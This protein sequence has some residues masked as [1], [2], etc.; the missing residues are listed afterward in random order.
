MRHFAHS[1]SLQ[2]TS[3]AYHYYKTLKITQKISLKE[4]CQSFQNRWH[5]EKKNELDSAGN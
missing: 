3:Q 1:H 5:S 4:I 2:H